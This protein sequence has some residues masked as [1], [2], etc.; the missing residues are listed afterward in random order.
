VGIATILLDCG[1]EAGMDESMLTTLDEAWRQVDLILISFPDLTHM[2]ALPLIFKRL[3]KRP[4]VYCTLPVQ[5]MGQMTLYDLF[6]SKAQLGS[7]IGFTLDDVDSVC[8]GIEVLKYS[9]SADIRVKAKPYLSITPFP[10]GRM[11]GGAIWRI[12]WRK[13]S[14][15]PCSHSPINCRIICLHV[16]HGLRWPL[17]PDVCGII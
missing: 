16:F 13:A 12:Q 6:L 3:T 8:Q 5:K 17:M 14:R 11:L 2:G 10:S 4:K 9:Q 1:W 15:T 7:S